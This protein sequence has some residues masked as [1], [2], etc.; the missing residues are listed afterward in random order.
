MVH[1][2][3]AKHNPK[4]NLSTLTNKT[5]TET[6]TEL[7]IL[8]LR[9]WFRFNKVSQGESG[10]HGRIQLSIHL[11]WVHNSLVRFKVCCFMSPDISCILLCMVLLQI[12]IFFSTELGQI[13]SEEL[14]GQ[15]QRVKQ[16]PL[17]LVGLLAFWNVQSDDSWTV[18]MHLMFFKKM[19]PDQVYFEEKKSLVLMA[20]VFYLLLCWFHAFQSL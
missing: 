2:I 18:H 12:E 3:N 13:C 10:L 7:Q 17:R 15:W 6:N 8:H 16:D 20:W 1:Y 11:V 5:I 4:C 19:F 14:S 9:M